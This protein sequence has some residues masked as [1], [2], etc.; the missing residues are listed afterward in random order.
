MI[1]IIVYPFFAAE[2]LRFLFPF[3]KRS[4]IFPTGIIT[5]RFSGMEE[6]HQ[7][8]HCSGPGAPAFLVSALKPGASYGMGTDIRDEN[9][10]GYGHAESNIHIALPGLLSR[11]LRMFFCFGGDYF[12]SHS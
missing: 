7:P 3:G 5:R 6:L 2:D 9:A 10:A 11:C 4:T 12:G 1:I 8:S